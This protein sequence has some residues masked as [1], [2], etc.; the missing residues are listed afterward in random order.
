M[1]IAHIRHEGHTYKV[2]VSSP[3]GGPAAL[4]AVFRQPVSEE[5][6]W[7]LIRK[8][9]FLNDDGTPLEGRAAKRVRDRLLGTYDHLP[10]RSRGGTR[11][12]GPRRMLIPGLWP[13]GHIP[14]MGGNPKAGKTTLV[15]DL[16]RALVIPGYR[17]LGCFDP[18][19]GLEYG[20][21][22]DLDNDR[23]RGVVLINAETPPV[24][25]EVAIGLDLEVETPEG[26]S[27]VG[28]YLYV[29]HLEELGG[30]NV[31]DVTRPE[32]YEL[33]THRLAECF[34][35]DGFDDRTPF[36]VIVDGVT[37]VLDNDT[38]RYGE[39][40]AAFRRLMREVDVPNALAVGHTTL[41][42]DHLMGGAEAQAGP[43]GLWT[44]SSADSDDP[45]A[46]RWFSVR[47]RLGGVVI[48]SSRV[49]LDPE[50]RPV[51]AREAAPSASGQVAA[52]GG[53]DGEGVALTVAYVQAHP[54]ADGAE[55]TE[56][57]NWGTKGMK[58]NARSRAVSGGLIT[59]A[60]CAAGCQVCAS[61][62]VRTFWKRSHYWPAAVPVP[63]G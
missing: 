38:N 23:E 30:A 2:Q 36:A 45:G 34:E 18:V 44:Y 51:M 56:A 22:V 3:T 48:P 47:P 57:V 21:G 13:W 32:I 49:T 15:A 17:F 42:G 5:R 53:D 40:Y 6:Q 10:G 63:E 43:D 29:E 25:L 60:R 62:G 59:E 20:G 1:S 58:L 4:K 54:G 39:W 16:T 55:I 9:E 33:W 46:S 19:E 35:C 61:R 28:R 50:G 24:D 52:D 31:F 7:E 12:D 41:K 8:G 14:M 37:A 27:S 26:S 11:G